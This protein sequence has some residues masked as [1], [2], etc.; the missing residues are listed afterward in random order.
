[1]VEVVFAGP[2]VGR[3]SPSLSLSLSLDVAVAAASHIGLCW[4]TAA[5]GSVTVDMLL[6]LL[7]LSLLMN[8]APAASFHSGA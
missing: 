8:T 3:H 7:S 5:V 6:S 4:S 2:F 1:M